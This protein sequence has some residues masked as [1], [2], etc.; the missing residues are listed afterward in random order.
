M[1]YLET[2]HKIY[3][4]AA[5]GFLGRDGILICENTYQYDNRGFC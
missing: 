3:K 4:A 1:N 2:T 5:L